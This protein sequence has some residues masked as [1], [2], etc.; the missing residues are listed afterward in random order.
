MRGVVKIF[1][2]RNGCG[3]IRC[4][5]LN[6]DVFVHVTNI[7]K[8]DGD[9]SDILVPGE[10]VEYE[11]YEGRKGKA[12]A[13]V[14]RTAPPVLME[15]VGKVKKYLSREGY[16]FITTEEGDVYFHSSDLLSPLVSSG[17]SVTYLRAQVDG[18]YR[19][20]RVTRRLT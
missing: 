12:A 13:N 3:F 16:G 10:E 20:L 8:N 17:D 19:A 5:E 9:P 6:E 18:K 4:S 11:V 15:L 7:I 14:I 1:K 2:T